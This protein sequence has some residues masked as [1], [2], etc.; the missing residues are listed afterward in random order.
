MTKNSYDRPT[1]F[2]DGSATALNDMNTVF[3]YKL[4]LC[5]LM[6]CGTGYGQTEWTRFRG[7]NGTGSSNA[8]SIPTKWTDNDYNWRIDL[9][10]IGHSSP[11]IWKKRIFVTSADPESAQLSILCFDVDDG[12]QLWR[13]DIKSKTHGQHPSSS[14]ADATPAVDQDGVI[15]SWTTPESYHVLALGLTGDEKWRRDLGPFVG[16]NGSGVSPI[17]VDELV[18][19]PNEQ[20]DVQL[21]ARLMGRENPDAPVGKSSIIALDRASGDIRWQLPRKTT[22]ASYSTPCIRE[23]QSGSKELILISEAQGISGV[24]VVTG[25]LKWEVRGLFS[26]R[27]VASPV[28][29]NDLVIGSHGEG[30]N[31]SLLVAVRAGNS[32]TADTATLAYEVKRAVPL[33]PSPLYHNGLLFLWADNGIVSCLDGETGHIHWR[34]R[35]GGNFY[36]SPIGVDKHVYCIA[37]NGAVVVLSA[38]TNYQLTARVPLGQTTYATPAVS[39]GVLYLRSESRLLSLGGN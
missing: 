13:K 31:G 6:L 21:L 25:E 8:N 22:L 11:V 5:V 36:S 10:G 37:R 18:L 33:V 2:L 24:N 20:D 4:A 15:V 17:I 27:C 28:L 3:N 23:T 14:Y 19:I 29:V 16:A 9:P 12:R 38:S 26:A 35:V 39:D 32:G 34:E 1:S 7:P 30:V